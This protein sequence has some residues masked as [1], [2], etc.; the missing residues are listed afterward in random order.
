MQLPHDQRLVRPVFRVGVSGVRQLHDGS[1]ATIA[2]LTQDLA[3]LIDRVAAALAALPAQPRAARCYAFDQEMVLTCLSSLAEGA[4]QWFADAALAARDKAAAGVRIDLTAVLPFAPEAYLGTFDQALAAASAARFG[5]L[6]DAVGERLVVLDGDAADVH[7]PAAYAATGEFI[8]HHCDLLVAVWD[9][10]VPPRGRGGTADTV[11][12]ALEAGVPVWWIDAAGRHPPCLLLDVIDLWRDRPTTPA[13]DALDRHVMAVLQPPEP[14]GAE[15]SAAGDDPLQTFLDEPCHPARNG[16]LLHSALIGLLRGSTRSDHG[17]LRR[18]ALAPVGRG[19]FDPALEVAGQLAEAYQHRYRTTYLVVLVA[20]A[21][22]LAAAVVDL[23]LPRWEAVATPGELAMLVVIVAAVWHATRRA[24]HERY[25]NY[26]LV[27][28]F[29][30]LTDHLAGWGQ[31]LPFAR[32]RR[33][34]GDHGQHWVAWLAAAHARQQPL[35]TGL[36][37]AQT[38]QWQAAIRSDLIADQ[39]AFHQARFEQC[40]RAGNRIGWLA[41][42][43]FVLTMVLALGKCAALV[44]PE[45]VEPLI[46]GNVFALNLATALLPALSAALF[47]IKAYEEFDQLAELSHHMIA[48]LDAAD[49][50]IAAIDPRHPL[51]SRMLGQAAAHVAEAMLAEVGGWAQMFRAR[52]V[53]E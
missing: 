33:T 13:W 35:P 20:G 19:R 40:E 49:R 32:M 43:L 42:A 45:V 8:V 37:A 16:W 5:T 44:M 50:R 29:V 41:K 18:A 3:L 48:D 53:E 36:I 30:R 2:G 27:G 21:L 46:G 24:L 25:I 7:Q 6:I 14:V 15:K 28:E 39:R 9:D 12:H 51:A 23:A 26:R 34:A 11:R 4:D 10:A 47:G 52:A 17:V 22:A 38:A 31:A 1:D